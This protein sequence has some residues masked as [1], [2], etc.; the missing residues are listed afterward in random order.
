MHLSFRL[1]SQALGIGIFY[2]AQK[3]ILYVHPLPLVAALVHLGEEWV[4][5]TDPTNGDVVR[6]TKARVAFM[7]TKA[8][9]RQLTD[10]GHTKAQIDAMSPEEANARIAQERGP[11]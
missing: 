4:E 1:G 5:V 11:R 6:M 2:H 9:R 10:L 8:M 3:R 7:I